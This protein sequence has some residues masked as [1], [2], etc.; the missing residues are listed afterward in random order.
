MASFK[1]AGRLEAA[2]VAL[3]AYRL[4]GRETAQLSRNTEE[5]NAILGVQKD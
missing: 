2:A 5:R 3:D 1:P 4:A